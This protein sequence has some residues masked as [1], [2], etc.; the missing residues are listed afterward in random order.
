M[1]SFEKAEVLFKKK[2]KR[3]SDERINEVKSLYPELKKWKNNSIDNM[4]SKYSLAIY[5]TQDAIWIK[6]RE[7]AVLG[8]ILIFDSFPDFNFGKEGMFEDYLKDFA[9]KKPWLEA[10]VKKPKWIEYSFL[11]E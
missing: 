1:Y 8:F 9:Q 2:S 6:E 3:L 11:T 4:W 7:D 10:D 5:M